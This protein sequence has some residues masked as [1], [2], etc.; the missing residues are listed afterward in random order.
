MR[1]CSRA[2]SAIS[3]VCCSAICARTSAPSWAR[4]SRSRQRASRAVI[5]SSGVAPAGGWA[6]GAAPVLRPIFC[7]TFFAP[8]STSGARLITSDQGMAEAMLPQGMGTTAAPSADE[9]GEF[10]ALVARRHPG[11]IH[12]LDPAGLAG[13]A[14]GFVARLAHL[15]GGLAGGLQV[16]PRVELGGVLGEELADGSRHG[17]ADV[18]VDVDLAHTELDAL[19]DLLDGH[20]IGLLHVAAVLADD[21]QEILGDRGGAVDHQVGVGKTGVDLFDAVYG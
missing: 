3:P 16:F 17:Q 21:R 15:L 12:R 18:G 13:A 20:A 4:V 5:R 19:D 1:R 10:P 6:V 2:T 11:E 8:R 7:H 14:E 9:L